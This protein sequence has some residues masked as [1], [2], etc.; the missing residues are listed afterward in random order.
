MLRGTKRKFSK[1]VP[2]SPKF[3]FF[4][5]NIKYLIKKDEQE[6]TGP[7]LGEYSLLL[8]KQCLLPGN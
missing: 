5:L 4:N 1:A 2:C 8:Q 3:L 6:T 7:D